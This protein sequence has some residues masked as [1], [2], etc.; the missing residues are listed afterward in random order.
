MLLINRDCQ[1]HECEQQSELW[2]H[3]L[4]SATDVPCGTGS[5]FLPLTNN[6]QA[7][8]IQ[9]LLSIMIITG[10]KWCLGAE[11]CIFPTPSKNLTLGFCADHLKMM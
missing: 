11:L 5:P 10:I 3:L 7:I 8:E 1:I 2:E 9:N 4:H 6:I